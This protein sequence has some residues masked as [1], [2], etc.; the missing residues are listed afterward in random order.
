MANIKYNINTCG[1]GHFLSTKRK[2]I[3]LFSLYKL[4]N[5]TRLCRDSLGPR[6]KLEAQIFIDAPFQKNIIMLQ[7]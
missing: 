7:H 3:D 6:T 1:R 2:N 5:E 4:K